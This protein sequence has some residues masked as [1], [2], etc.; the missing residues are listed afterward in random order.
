MKQ[1]G[2]PSSKKAKTSARRYNA[3]TTPVRGA[4]PDQSVDEVTNMLQASPLMNVQSSD[5]NYL[6]S[7]IDMIY[8]GWANEMVI[9]RMKEL[10]KDKNAVGIRNHH[11]N[12]L[13]GLLQNYEGKKIEK[14]KQAYNKTQKTLGES[15]NKLEKSKKIGYDGEKK[16]YTANFGEALDD[17]TE[18]VV[19]ANYAPIGDSK[20]QNKQILC[21]IPRDN[22]CM[23]KFVK[24]STDMRYY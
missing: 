8:G 6:I 10:V 23:S 4:D 3:V 1:R 9:Y 21:R 19:L 17:A 22:I 24:V 12:Y 15:I 14:L 11:R 5:Y 13:L 18:G 7:V 2:S 16:T 20:P